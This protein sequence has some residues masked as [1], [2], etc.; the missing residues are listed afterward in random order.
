MPFVKQC[1]SSHIWVV[2]S[3]N[4]HIKLQQPLP[5]IRPLVFLKDALISSL[6]FLHL[7][8]NQYAA[9]L[10]GNIFNVLLNTHEPI[11]LHCTLWNSPVIC[12][13]GCNWLN[14]H[15]VGLKMC[16]VNLATRLQHV[17]YNCCAILLHQ[18]LIF[19]N[20][21][22][23]G[24]PVIFAKV[25]LKIK[26]CDTTTISMSGIVNVCELLRAL[27]VY[28]AVFLLFHSVF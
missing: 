8:C 10:Y 7:H 17:Y 13:S 24:L 6:M 18:L 26:E 15:C 4:L 5:L 27:Y 9:F 25:C 22:D 20:C 1:V 14:N 23:N 2:G 11:K 21:S 19:S 28:A 16:Q 3:V 12:L